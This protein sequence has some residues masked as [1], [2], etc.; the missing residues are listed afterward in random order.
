VQKRCAIRYYQARQPNPQHLP[1]HFYPA[2]QS[3]EPPDYAL[4]N[5]HMCLH[6]KA[7]DAYSHLEP[8]FIFVESP[9]LTHEKAIG[10]DVEGRPA[11]QYPKT[12]RP[13][14]SSEEFQ[15]MDKMAKLLEHKVDVLRG[16][17]EEK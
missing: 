3:A 13:D 12:G 6:P 10:V 14:S 9:F 2:A 16:Q 8:H 1:Q 7:I 17:A 15:A 5:C 4:Q 11:A